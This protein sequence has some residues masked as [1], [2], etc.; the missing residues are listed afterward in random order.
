MAHKDRAWSRKAEL[1]SDQKALRER[2]RGELERIDAAVAG[3]PELKMGLKGLPKIPEPPAD[4][5][6]WEQSL[7]TVDQRIADQRFA[8]ELQPNAAIVG[9][10]LRT[11]REAAQLQSEHL[12]N[13][14]RSTTTD[15]ELMTLRP[16][17]E[18]K[19]LLRDE[20]AQAEKAI[21]DAIASIDAV[22]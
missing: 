20:R 22:H 17:V 3:I 6:T 19:F 10:F 4:C 15:S 8:G 5:Y 14:A 9:A 1:R 13:L 2:L 12:A 18:K 16:A 7:L 11:W 21:R